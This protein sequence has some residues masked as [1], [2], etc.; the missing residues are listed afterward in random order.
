MKKMTNEEFIV[1][2]KLKH[3]DLYDYKYTN[4]TNV[5]NKI[6]I[7]CK[8]HGS[9]TQTASSHLSG[10]GCKKCKYDNLKL[11]FSS[12]TDDFIK[13]SNII[14]LN[15]YKY[16]NSQYIN[17]YESI[18][19]TCIKH[20]DFLQ[21]PYKHLSGQG[22]PKCSGKYKTNE[23]FIKK[24]QNIHKNKF[25]YN[26]VN[27]INSKT[28]VIITCNQHGDFSQLPNNHIQGQ[29]CPKC[30]TSKSEYKITEFLNNNNI[31]FIMEHTYIDCCY[32]RKLPFDFY[33]PAYNLCIEFDGEQHFKSIK[34]FGGEK[35]LLI[36]KIKDNIKT[37]YCKNNNIKLLRIPYYDFNNIEK[38][39]EKI[40]L[41]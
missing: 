12:N 28:N 34:H 7:Y 9:F 18:K 4:F 41:T 21:K 14:H 23:E 20:G 1:K 31:K 13:K 27:Y 29:G 30:N 2:S 15:K 33:L 10:S 19:I 36:Q 32:K 37:E 22:C 38:I 5:R 3:G 17:S 11:K 6:D 40:L 24:A 25:S 35:R 39:L 26:L 16:I 8:I